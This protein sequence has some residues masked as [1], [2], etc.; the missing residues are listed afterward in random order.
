MSSLGAP[1]GEGPPQIT[2]QILPPELVALSEKPS[3]PSTR[4]TSS[5]TRADSD[6]INETA[7]L[8]EPRHAELDS[9]DSL[10][11][12]KEQ[13]SV[14]GGRSVKWGVCWK[15]PSL[16]ILWALVGLSLALGHHFYY[17]S[18]N[19]TKAGS[20][21]RQ[22]RSVLFGTTSALLVIASL[23]ASCELTYGQYIWTLFKRKGFSL[24]I[25]DKLFSATSDPTS[26]FSWE[27]VRHARVAF[28]I[29]T[30][31]W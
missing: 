20:S 28:L 19:G 7:Y 4:R 1:H 27:F 15:T 2:I 29:A 30:L 12:N 13:H 21:T 14:P 22:S 3:F 10:I 8:E 31:C 16:M 26:F 6:A 18:L 25:L 11:K 9:H 23:T 17:G 24:N 5:T